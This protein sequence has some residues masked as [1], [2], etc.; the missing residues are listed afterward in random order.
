MI[1]IDLT[2]LD[3]LPNTMNFVTPNPTDFFK[4]ELTIKPDEGKY[5]FEE[6]I[7]L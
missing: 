1:I 3:E 7:I 2:D 6:K 4:H 5:K